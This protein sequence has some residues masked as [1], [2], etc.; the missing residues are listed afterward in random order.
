MDD[1]HPSANPAPRR[2]DLDLSF[3][4]L[5]FRHLLESQVL[6]AVESHGVH[7]LSRGRSHDVGSV[8]VGMVM[9][10]DVG[11]LS[12]VIQDHSKLS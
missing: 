4:T 6:F 11:I 7:H 9:V 8:S 1:T 12:Q 2:L 3:P 10:M 5:G